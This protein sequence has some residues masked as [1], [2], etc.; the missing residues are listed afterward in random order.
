M[1]TPAAGVANLTRYAC[2]FFR[3]ELIL[4]TK[5]GS[6]APYTPEIVNTILAIVMNDITIFLKFLSLFI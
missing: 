4:F 6:D 1:A 3:A 2:N 5:V